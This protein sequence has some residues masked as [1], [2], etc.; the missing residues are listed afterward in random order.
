MDRPWGV[1][2]FLDDDCQAL[3]KKDPKE[4][5]FWVENQLTGVD[6]DPKV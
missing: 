3:S 5:N 4:N 6:S 1:P 2:G